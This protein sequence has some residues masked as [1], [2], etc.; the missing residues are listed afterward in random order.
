MY[1][2]FKRIYVDVQLEEQKVILLIQNDIINRLKNVLRLRNGD[3]I[4]IFNPNSGEY[5]AVI[6][7][8]QQKQIEIKIDH[9]IKDAELPKELKIIVPIIKPDRFRWMIE[10]STELG[11]SH[12]TIYKPS[13]GQFDKINLEKI[14]QYAI[15]ACEQSERITVPSIEVIQD[16]AKFLSTNKS[17]ILFC[18]EYENKVSI[19]N[20]L[21]IEKNVNTILVGPEGGFTHDEII[22]LRNKDNVISTYLGDKIL[23][24]ETA[25][26]FG[27]SAL[28]VCNNMIT[29]PARLK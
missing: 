19:I 12:I 6:N 27:L 18:N 20:A 1:N 13:R 26:I 29:N 22:G 5:L 9:K 10:K 24:T 17:K 7:L 21:D 14:Y 16:L 2:N 28:L 8:I 15:G 23:R 4:K 25:V 3:K 11:V